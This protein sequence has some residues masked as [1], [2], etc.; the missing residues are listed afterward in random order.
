MQQ[1]TQRSSGQS[2]APGAKRR[3]VRAGKQVIYEGYDQDEAIKVFLQAG[4]D[5]PFVRITYKAGRKI[6]A[7]IDVNAYTERQVA[8]LKKRAAREKRERTSYRQQAI[9]L[10][11]GQQALKEQ[12]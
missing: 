9:I 6:E 1:D 3:V 7:S 11:T 8:A 4:K 10:T 2:K 5:Y 12:R